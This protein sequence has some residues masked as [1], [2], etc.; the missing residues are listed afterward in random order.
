MYF[1]AVEDLKARM[2]D[3]PLS[4][5]EVLPY[6]IAFVAICAATLFIADPISD[7]WRALDASLS[8]LLA[9]AGTIYIF[10]RNGGSA[11][12]H[13]L[14][15]YFAV[16]WVVG[17][18]MFVIIVCVGFAFYLVLQAAR[19]G[20]DGTTWYEVVLHAATEALIYWR[21]GCHVGDLARWK[22]PAEPVRPD[23]V[24]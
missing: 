21:I 7:L 16:G 9:V 6:L 2:A 12:E 1:W 18:R 23:N 4:D 10:R 5:R 22:K 24:G 15:R 3:R 8:V 13:F 17:V 20:T 19:I 11:G 14:Q